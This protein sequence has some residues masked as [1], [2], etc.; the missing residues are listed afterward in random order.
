MAKRR[1]GT[2]PAPSPRRRT[3]APSAPRPFL[4]GVGGGVAV[5]ALLGV[6]L[7]TALLVDPTAYASFDAPKRLAAACG[8]ALA[9]FA[10]FGL[11][12]RSRAGRRTWR[13]LPGMARI[14]LLATAGALAWGA[15]SALLS[16]DRPVALDSLRTILLFCL[17]LPLGASA[18]V[19]RRRNLLLGATIATAAVNAGLS[20]LQSRGMSLFHLQTFGT[21]NETGALAGNVGYLALS[22][23]FAAV[24]SLGILISARGTKMRILA[25]AGLLLLLA[26]L[27]VNRNLTA[28]IALAIGGSVLLVLF[29]GRRSLVPV[30]AVVVALAAA[31]FL[32]APFK[33]RVGDAVG[34]I[35]RGDWDRLTTYRTGAWAAAVQM[36][37]ERPIVGWGP[38][39]YAAEFTPH[40]L[41]AEIRARRRYVNPLLTSSYSEAHCD[42]LQA[43]AETGVPGG[44]AVLVAVGALFAAVGRRAVKAGPNRTEAAI[45]TGL[46]AA[47]AAAALTWFPLQRPISAAP[48]LLAAGRSWRIASERLEDRA[49]P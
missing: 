40:R 49:N 37:R 39:T 16:P 17:L 13:D 41:E 9:A 42:Y 3:S 18:P 25:A 30:V 26:G 10:A 6:V 12:L 4:A 48:L 24:L 22:L 7:G 47:G 43:F 15:L 5:V 28:I 2:K 29:F 35:R 36:T 38:G 19:A 20:I 1:H 11:G 45:L 33:Q 32:V 23:A 27:F 21:R 34:M 31:S 44:L 46:L 8:A 14:A